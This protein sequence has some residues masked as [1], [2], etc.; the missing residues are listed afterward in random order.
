M[1]SN[2]DYNYNNY[3]S[4]DNSGYGQ[5]GG[6]D[7]FG[8]GAPGG[9]GAPS[10]NNNEEEF[11]MFAPPGSSPVAANSNL[12]FYNAAPSYPPA[13][14]AVPKHGAAAPA[15]GYG[16]S[17]GFQQPQQNVNSFQMGNNSQA[18]MQQPGPS[19]GSYNQPS[20]Q[21]TPGFNAFT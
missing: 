8:F 1:N 14:G 10:S 7:N 9:G 4:G 3:S 12:D 6:V 5:Q 15:G 13:T 19:F 20:Y 21:E 2:F 16:S 17:S 18:P 11:V